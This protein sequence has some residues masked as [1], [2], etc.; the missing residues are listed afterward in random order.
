MNTVPVAI[1]LLIS[2]SFSINYSILIL[3]FSIFNEKI[4]SDHV[5]VAVI[6]WFILN[7][8]SIGQSESH[9]VQN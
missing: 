7:R 3:G 4:K 2:L 1:T 8:H 6:V 9:L 5:A